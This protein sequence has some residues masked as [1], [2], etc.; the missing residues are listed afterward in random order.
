MKVIIKNKEPLEKDD[1]LFG[2]LSQ[3]KAHISYLRIMLNEED[4]KLSFQLSDNPARWINLDPQ[5]YAGFRMLKRSEVGVVKFSVKYVS[6]QNLLSHFTPTFGIKFPTGKAEITNQLEN[7]DKGF[8]TLDC[9]SKYLESIV[10][11]MRKIISMTPQ[12]KYEII[13]TFLS[14]NPAAVQ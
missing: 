6:P 11:A 10:L 13:E 5:K 7:T 12:K 9:S 1:S 3:H 2:L 8:F 4:N 14:A